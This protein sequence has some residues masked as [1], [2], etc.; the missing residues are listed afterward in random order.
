MR[1]GPIRARGWDPVVAAQTIRFR[2]SL[3]RWQ[4]YT[5]TTRIV[6]WSER[7]VYLEQ[8]F[9]RGAD[10]QRPAEAIGTVRFR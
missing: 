10:R 7:S 2:R 6:G 8:V 9:A 3:T 1:S 4:R 5:I